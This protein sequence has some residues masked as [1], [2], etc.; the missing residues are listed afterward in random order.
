[1][2][3]FKKQSEKQKNYEGERILQELETETT[4]KDDMSID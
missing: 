3:Q 4:T 2:I 1:M